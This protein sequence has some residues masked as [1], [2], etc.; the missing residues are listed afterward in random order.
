MSPGTSSN[1]STRRSFGMAT[2]RTKRR[3]SSSSWF[4]FFSSRIM[5][6]PLC[7]GVDRADR[8][9]ERH[10]P[11]SVFAFE[12]PRPEPKDFDAAVDRQQPATGPC[13]EGCSD[14]M[15]LRAEVAQRGTEAPL[16]ALLDGFFG[17]PTELLPSLGRL[18]P[19]AGNEFLASL[20]RKHREQRPSHRRANQ[21][22]AEADV[23]Q[24]IGSAEKP[25]R[26]EIQR[27][28]AVDRAER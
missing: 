17:C 14:G 19:D 20:L 4:S 6:R 15:D 27:V 24:V 1:S 9:G 18:A 25:R 5:L 11:W 12:L 21:R 23:R 2:S 28:H 13:H 8:G 7:C 3:T 26:F 16:K 22:Q 10:E